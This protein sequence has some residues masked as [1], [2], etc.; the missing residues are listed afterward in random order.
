MRGQA[1]RQAPLALTMAAGAVLA[2][3][4]AGGG[5]PAQAETSLQTAQAEPIEARPADARCT[6]YLPTRVRMKEDIG[7]G[8]TRAAVRDQLIERMLLQAVRQESGSLLR[9]AASSLVATKDGETRERF[10]Q[11]YQ[12]QVRGFATFDVLRDRRG[13]EGEQE[14]LELEIAA[15][16]CVPRHPLPRTVAVVETRSTQGAPVPELRDALRTAFSGSDIFALTSGDN[17]FIDIELRAGINHVGVV[18]LT[19]LPEQLPAGQKGLAG[20][21]YEILTDMNA[22]ARLSESGEV[23]TARRDETERRSANADRRQAAEQVVK[24]EMVAL[25][26][27]LH[28]SLDQTLRRRLARLSDE[29]DEREIAPRPE[30]SRGG[31]L[32]H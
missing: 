26:E 29:T 30:P 31:G 4:V 12:S 2:F 16:V 19:I 6:A 13:F 1:T 28:R 32:N 21:Y 25:A 17:A 8:Q 24:A 3:S 23:F 14:V 10:M 5:A 20:D 11:R 7:A 9:G 22:Q 27:D 18:D 15:Q